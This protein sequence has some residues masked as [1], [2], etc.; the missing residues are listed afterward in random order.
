MHGEKKTPISNV[1]LVV[2]SWS[3]HYDSGTSYGLDINGVYVNL[4]DENAEKILLAIGYGTTVWEI[5][6]QLVGKPYEHKDAIKP[7]NRQFV[8]GKFYYSRQEAEEV[9]NKEIA[10]RIAALKKLTG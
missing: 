7:R 9:V 1:S 5:D 3:D 10:S 4:N 6:W 2:S 8:T